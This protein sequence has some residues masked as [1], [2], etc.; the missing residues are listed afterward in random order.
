MTSGNMVT[1]RT[2]LPAMTAMLLAA[3]RNCILA[4]VEVVGIYEIPVSRSAHV[5]DGDVTLPRYLVHRRVD[6]IIHLGRGERLAS[7]GEPDEAHCARPARGEMRSDADLTDRR[8]L[9]APFGGGGM[10]DD[11]HFKSM[12][13]GQFVRNARI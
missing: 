12:P 11:V 9:H 13:S 10:D 5:I 2:M 4:S 6:I 3:L 1:R 8:H 7:A